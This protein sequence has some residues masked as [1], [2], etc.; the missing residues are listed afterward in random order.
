M[1]IFVLDTD[2]RLAAEAQFDA[3]VVK[4]TLETAQLL[5]ST[6]SPGLAPYKPT[7]QKH[8]CAVW[9]RET[10]ANFLWLAEHG[11]YLADEYERR[12][13]R[14]HKSRGV[15]LWCLDNI[16]MANVDHSGDLTPFAQAMPE[17]YRQDDPVAAYRAYYLGAKHHIARWNKSRPPPAW[18]R[19]E[20]PRGTA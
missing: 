18:W 1:N 8:P 15:I 12:Y 2:P 13:E 5:C 16:A 4:M 11:L 3:H 7:H 9:A 17:E 6:F 10:A 14:E 19:S 20:V